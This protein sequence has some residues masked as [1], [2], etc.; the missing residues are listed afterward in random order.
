MAMSTTV[1]AEIVMTEPSNDLVKFSTMSR[2]SLAL[3][4]RPVDGWLWE[5]E[6]GIIHQPFKKESLT[7][8]RL[9]SFVCFLADLFLNCSILICFIECVF[10]I[11]G[12]I[13]KIIS[14]LLK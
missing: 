9:D 6:G 3:M 14:N 10:K 7:S 11:R 13:V 5:F 4:N 8:R 2:A 12:F 1:F